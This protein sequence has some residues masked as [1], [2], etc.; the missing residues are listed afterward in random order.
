MMRQ[1]ERHCQCHVTVTG[2]GTVP[3]PPAR[4]RFGLGGP[5]LGPFSD[6]NFGMCLDLSQ[7]GCVHAGPQIYLARP[8]SLFI[9]GPR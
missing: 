1:L 7:I 6:I 9:E 8:P 4:G 3:G 5:G 2:T